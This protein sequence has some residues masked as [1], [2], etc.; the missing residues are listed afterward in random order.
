MGAS[1]G[2]GKVGEPDKKG[3]GAGSYLLAPGISNYLRLVARSGLAEVEA[4]SDHGGVSYGR[5]GFLM[6][7][8]IGIIRNTAVDF[9]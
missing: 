3:G 5:V 1:S 4:P 7:F 2:Q 8:F 6:D 9:Q